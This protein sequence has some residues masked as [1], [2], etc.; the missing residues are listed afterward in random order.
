MSLSNGTN[1]EFLNCNG[2]DWNFCTQSTIMDTTTIRSTTSHRPEG[3]TS[4][5]ATITVT[6]T[7][8]EEATDSTNYT[9]LARDVV[10][11]AFTT[12]SQSIPHR[13]LACQSEAPSMSVLTGKV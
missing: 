4:T 1:I 10:F 7:Q 5:S 9:I 11:Y 12:S 13:D 6:M 8:P 3:N 2:Y